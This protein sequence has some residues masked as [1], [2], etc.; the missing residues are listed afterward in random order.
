MGIGNEAKVLERC[1]KAR[2]LSRRKIPPEDCQFP[3]RGDGFN[4]VRRGKT[5]SQE[6]VGANHSSYTPT[7]NDQDFSPFP[8]T[9]RDLEET[10]QAPTIPKIN[11]EALARRPSPIIVQQKPPNNQ[12][13]SKK[14]K[15]ILNPHS[16]KVRGV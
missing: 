9:E 13:Q 1:P 15:G 2:I 11:L 7:Q 12:P 10:K 14:K 6:M 4:I 3:A 5:G 16:W 8:T